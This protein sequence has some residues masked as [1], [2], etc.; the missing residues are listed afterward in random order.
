M[1]GAHQPSENP[2]DLM[3]LQLIMQPI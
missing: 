1:I 2:I 3:R